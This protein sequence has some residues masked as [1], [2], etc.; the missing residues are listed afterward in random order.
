MANNRPNR[1]KDSIVPSTMARARK[2]INQW[3]SALQAAENAE[4]PNRTLLYNLFDEL[5]LDTHLTSELQKR[6]MAIK[7]SEFAIVDSEGVVDPEKTAMLM[8]P[9]FFK[10]LQYAMESIEWGHSLVQIEDFEEGEIKDISLVPR[11]H[12]IPEKGIVIKRIGD[13]KGIDYREDQMYARWLFEVGSKTDLGLL[14]KAAPQ[15]LYKRFAQG[16]WSEFCEIFGMP[17]RVA[18]TD[19]QNSDS[20]DK[21]E[22]M[23]VNMAAAGFAIIHTDEELEFIETAKSNGEVYSGLISLAN[24]EISKLITGA[25]IGEASKDGSR[26][27]EEVGERIGQA[28]TK[29]D[30][31]FVAG[32]VNRVLL[33]K[34]IEFGYGLEGYSFAFQ[35]SIDLAALWKMTSEVLQH[36]EVDDQYIID[37]FGIPVTG[38][39]TFAPTPNLKSNFFA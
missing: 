39:K 15:I 38:K 27:K 35:K 32:W 3:R 9:W 12:V 37:T 28:I 20:L 24:A 7:G 21:L 16:A 25:V 34:L 10:A 17:L 23:M 29:G 11:R 4:R 19:T 33:P 22:N 6:E 2:D 14:N 13:E 31:L 1:V 18:K 8:K 36:Y 26:S 5:V 30:K